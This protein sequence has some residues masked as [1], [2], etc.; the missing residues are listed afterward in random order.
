MKPKKFKESNVVFGENQPGYLPSPAFLD[1]GEQGE[2]VI[3]WELSLRE[4]LRI[5]FKGVMWVSLP[6]FHRSL[7]PIFI[8]TKKS[9]VLITEEVDA[10]ES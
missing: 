3:C 6:S 4:R 5:L 8:T 7:A 9:D 10:N 1:S 2:V